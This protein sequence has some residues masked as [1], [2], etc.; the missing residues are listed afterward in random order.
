[1]TTNKTDSVCSVTISSWLADLH[2]ECY[3][4][5]L[6]EYEN[7]KVSLL[8]VLDSCMH[9]SMVVSW[10][11]APSLQDCVNVWLSCT[12][13]AAESLAPATSCIV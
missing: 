1:M 3:K 4:K 10:E 5:N 6:E 7:I 12:N 2:M 9:A 11:V 13:S 8:L